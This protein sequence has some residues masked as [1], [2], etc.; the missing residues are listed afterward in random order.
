MGKGISVFTGM[1]FSLEDNLQYIKDAQKAGF[2][3]IFTSLHIP[4]ANYE[5]AI[6]EFQEITRLANSLDMKIIADISPRAFKYLKGDINNLEPISNLGIFAIRVDFG[7]TPLE[8]AEFTRNPFG[9]KV[10]INAS[11]V[12]ERF[13]DEFEKCNPNYKML[14]ASHNYYPRLNTGLSEDVLIM[15]NNLLKKYKIRISAF[16]PL[17]S[18]KRGP[19]FEGLPTLEE[20]R[21]LESSISAKHLYAIGIDNVFIGDSIATKKEL[22]TIGEISQEIIDFNVDIYS[23]NELERKIIFKKYHENRSDYARDVVRSTISREE[24]N[25]DDIIYPSNNI[26]RKR[27]Y[28]TI[29]NKDYLRYFG[30]LQICLKDLPL[31][32]RVNVV[33]LIKEEELFLLNYIKEETKFKFKICKGRN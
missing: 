16:V 33:G 12:T 28:I 14:Q 10:E 7:F 1:K 9:L 5:K 25:K 29:D 23:K 17:L 31:D 6:E 11:T 20:H 26:E 13:L 18:E 24:L 3:R 8:I 4:E 32:N 22:E 30:E 27:G 19:I 15:K 2:D 21:F